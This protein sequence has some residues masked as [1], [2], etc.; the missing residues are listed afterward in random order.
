MKIRK[1]SAK[2]YPQIL[3][4]LN[5]YIKNTTINFSQT[6]ITILDLSK[7]VDTIT[8]KYPF[9]VLVENE[10]ILG[11]AYLSAFN[12]K[13]SYDITADLSIYLNPN[14]KSKGYGKILLNEIET[15]AKK[16][17]IK[18]II[19]IITAENHKSLAFH[20]QNGF[21]IVGQLEKVGYK[22]N[23]YLDVY[24]YQKKLSN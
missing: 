4:I 5:Y 14:V 2:D 9:I 19:S 18:N 24:Y 23:R 16:Q 6:P 15:L 7:M 17:D 22:F 3:E 12:P 10:T 20:Q 21:K 11:Y 8:T 1:I 13:Q